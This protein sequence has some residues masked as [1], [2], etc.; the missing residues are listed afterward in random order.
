MQ[1]D[2]DEPFPPENDRD[3]ED[4]GTPKT[5]N[6]DAVTKFGVMDD[7]RM[8]SVIFFPVNP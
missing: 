5:W 1:D 2:D 3:R 4:K 7:N 6:E 8:K